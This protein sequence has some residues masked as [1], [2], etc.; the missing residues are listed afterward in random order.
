MKPVSWVLLGLVVVALAVAGMASPFRQVHAGPATVAGP[1][2]ADALTIAAADTESGQQ[3][4]IV[5]R[6]SRVMSVYHVER[7]SGKISLK[8]VRNMTWDMQMLQWNS[9]SP[10]PQEVR[11]ML[12]QRE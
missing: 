10:L 9:Q 11:T 7:D 5:D 4:V 8:S 1:G 6:Q 12:Q 2:S 3:I